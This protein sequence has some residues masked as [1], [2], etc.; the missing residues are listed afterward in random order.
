MMNIPIGRKIMAA[1]SEGPREPACRCASIVSDATRI[2]AQAPRRAE[3]FHSRSFDDL[4]TGVR[5]E[6]RR[7]AL[8]VSSRQAHGARKR[9]AAVRSE[10]HG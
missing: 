10:E 7:G 4:P 9:C 6:T 5:E 1:F 8:I 3:A 2:E